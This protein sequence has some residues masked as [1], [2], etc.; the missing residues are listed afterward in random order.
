[1]GQSSVFH[2]KEYQQEH[3]R[4]TLCPTRE[5]GL[6]LGGLECKPR[7][8]SPQPKTLGNWILGD[9]GFEACMVQGFRVR[10]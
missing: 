9:Q 10:V 4:I 8:L 1:M 3:T 7:T 5:S 2:Y 6:V